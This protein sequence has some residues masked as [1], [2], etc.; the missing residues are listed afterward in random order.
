VFF[1]KAVL[2]FINSL[3]EVGGNSLILATFHYSSRVHHPVLF[4]NQ[5]QNYNWSDYFSFAENLPYEDG[6]CCAF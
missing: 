6:N 5:S 1:Y 3:V 2:F 4:F